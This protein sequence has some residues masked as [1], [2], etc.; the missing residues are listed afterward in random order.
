MEPVEEPHLLPVVMVQPALPPISHQLAPH[1]VSLQSLVSS[2]FRLY[3]RIATHNAGKI[4]YYRLN[5]RS[6]IEPKFRKINCIGREKSQL[7]FLSRRA[8]R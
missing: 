7:R 4:L 8:S 3:V 2:T 1:L 5:L 6:L